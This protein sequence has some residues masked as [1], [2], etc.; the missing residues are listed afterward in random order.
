[1]YY[2]CCAYSMRSGNRLSQQKQTSRKKKKEKIM[3]T[4]IL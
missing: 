2:E 1:M 4:K 3:K